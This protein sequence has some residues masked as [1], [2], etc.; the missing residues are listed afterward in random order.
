MGI[1]GVTAITP[2]CHART[3]RVHVSVVLRPG[4]LTRAFRAPAQYDL[5]SV[6]RLPVDQR[7]ILD[8]LI[9]VGCPAVLLPRAESGHTIKMLSPET[10]ELVRALKEPGPL[11]PGAVDR[12]GR[13]ADET[14]ARLVLDDMLEIETHSGF[15][16]GVAASEVVLQIEDPEA[17]EGL[18]SELSWSA[19]QFGQAMELGE[20]LALAR[21]LYGYNA[22]PASPR[23]RHR[24]PTTRAVAEF[25]GLD[26]FG[27]SLQLV[28]SGSERTVDWRHGGAWWSW[29]AG[30]A[31]AVP[32]GRQVYKLYVS[33]E[34]EQL[35]DAFHTVIGTIGKDGPFCFKVG[36]DLLG[37][38]RPD[39]LVAYFAHQEQLQ[40]ASER[41]SDEL[42]GMRPQGVPFTAD[43]GANGL[44][45]WA[46]DPPRDD[47]SP[48]W[49]RDRSW[50]MWI[51]HLLAASLHAARMT[52]RAP[53]PPW[54]FAQVR[55]A[56][57]GVN[58]QTWAPTPGPWHLA[59]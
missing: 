12:L 9:R 49:Y 58:P 4:L 31:D 16:S 37:I 28:E 45:S 11:P 42:D 30:D 10:T 17:P 46:V 33:P 41:L 35:R 51:T 18:L 2:W 36:R 47:W 3:Q 13:R 56:L 5:V 26:G 29:L 59:T 21:R 57:E 19:L 20:P 43:A 1:R 15:V 7:R 38:L 34:V 8:D 22:V 39:K 27:A 54:H 25:L 6:E 40:A 48:Q 53:L 55:V 23:Y 50:R 24:F 44:L 14:I 52:A 32:T